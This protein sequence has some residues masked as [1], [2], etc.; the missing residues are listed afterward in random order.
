MSTVQAAVRL[1]SSETWAN[2]EIM[3]QIFYRFHRSF[4][5]T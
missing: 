2:S 4:V 3:T 1:A 5:T